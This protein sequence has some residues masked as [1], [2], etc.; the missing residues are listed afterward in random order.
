MYERG[1]IIFDGAHNNGNTKTISAVVVGLGNYGTEM[2]KTL[3]WYGQMDGYRLKINAFDKDSLAEEKFCAQAPELMDATYNGAE[4]AGTANYH[5]AIHSGMD[6]QT[7]SFAKEIRKITDATYVFVALGNDDQ[8]ISTAVMLRTYFERMGLHPA[9]HAVVKNA[10]QSKALEGIVNFRKQPYDVEFVGDIDSSFTEAVIIDHELE[11]EGLAIHMKW[12]AE[13]EFWTYEY[14]YRSSIA[15]AIHMKARIHCGIPGAGKKEEDLTDGEK[16]IIAGLEHRRWNAYMR[17]EGY[18]HGDARN[19]LA[20]VHHNL[21]DY[22][23]LDGA[24][25][26]KTQSVGTK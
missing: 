8:N 3:S 11:D 15:S 12:G 21:T 16:D 23:K 10:Q 1:H 24:S 25:K 22:S 26:H 20:K 14:N 18:V 4:I 17:S 19:D 2:L 13:E 7:L 6:V 5:I 9:I